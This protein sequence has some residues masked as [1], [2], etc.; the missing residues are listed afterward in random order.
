M[1]ACGKSTFGSLWSSSRVRRMWSCRCA[2]EAGGTARGLVFFSNSTS[3]QYRHSLANSPSNRSTIKFEVRSRTLFLYCCVTHR[4]YGFVNVSSFRGN[5]NG[6]TAVF[7]T[8]NY[9]YM[10]LIHTGSS[11]YLGRYII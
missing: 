7:T 1:Q 9:T 5:R 3:L 10:K 8:E 11:I 2:S 4:G 6:K